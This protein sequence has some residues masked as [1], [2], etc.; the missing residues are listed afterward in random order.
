ML[1]RD[2]NN[3]RCFNTLLICTVQGLVGFLEALSSPEFQ[4]SEGAGVQALATKITELNT[5]S[6]AA[7]YRVYRQS[8][9]V[10]VLLEIITP[11]KT[12]SHYVALE[13]WR[14]DHSFSNLDCFPPLPHTFPTLKRLLSS[15]LFLFF[16]QNF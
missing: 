12:L 13:C 4:P 10:G 7:M 16:L 3:T 14:K 1:R 11:Q 8:A 6:I 15:F 9:G 5:S 2:Y